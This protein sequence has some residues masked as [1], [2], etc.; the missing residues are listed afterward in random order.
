M[1]VPRLYRHVHMRSLSQKVSQ[2]ICQE[3]LGTQYAVHGLCERHEKIWIRYPALADGIVMNNDPHENHHL[4]LE[5]DIS[6]V[7][8]KNK[9][10]MTMFYFPHTF[11]VTHKH[12]YIQHHGK[13][14]ER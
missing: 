3:I 4:L 11:L 5:S 13:K 6:F 9:I 8:N 1:V 2:I 10:N 7:P 12:T 14:Q